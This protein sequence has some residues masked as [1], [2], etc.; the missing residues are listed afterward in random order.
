MKKKVN[1]ELKNEKNSKIKQFLLDMIAPVVLLGITIALFVYGNS[2]KPVT[3]TI[4][5][6]D[7]YSYEGSEDPITLE[8]GDY[9]LYVDPLTTYITVENKK[10][11][12]TWTSNPEEILTAD[13]TDEIANKLK[14]TLILEYSNS[15]GATIDPYYNYKYSI[16]KSIYDIQKNGDVITVNYSIGD[17]AKT[18]ICPPVCLATEF[19]DYLKKI[20]ASESGGTKIMRDVKGNYKKWDKDKVG[21]YDVDQFEIIKERYPKVLEEPI[22]VLRDGLGKTTMEKTERAFVGIGYSEEDY[23][24]DKELDNQ[25]ASSNKPIFNV[26]IQYKL[27]GNKLTVTV[28]FDKIECPADYPAIGLS[29]LPYFDAAGKD[30][31]GFMVVPEGG[32]SVINFNNGKT[33]MEAYASKIYGRDLCLTKDSLVHDPISTFGVIGSSRGDHS[34]IC[35]P[36]GCSSYATIYADIYRQK[37]P[38]NNIY[39]KYDLFQREMYDMGSQVSTAIYKYIDELPQ[40]EKITQ[41]YVFLDKGNYVDMAEA[42][43]EHLLKEYGSYMSKNSDSSTPVNVEIIGAADKTEQILGIPVN[44]PL[45][46][47]NFDEASEIANDLKNSVGMKNVNLKLV[48]WCNGGVKQTVLSSASPVSKLG[49]KSG[50]KSFIETAKGLGYNVSLN[51]IVMYAIDSDLF[52]GFFSFTDAAKTI[53]QERME[54]FKYSAVTFALREGTEPYYLL[55]TDLI[56]KY[57]DNL[58]ET[59]DNYGVGVS[60]DDFGKDLAADYYDDKFYSREKV[61]SLQSDLFKKLRDGGKYVV[62]NSGNEYAIPYVDMITNMDLKGSDYSILDENIPFLEFAIHG[63][64]NYTGESLNI[65]GDMSE[66]LLYSA[67]Y[68]AGLSFTY[69]KESPFTLQDTLYTHY[70]GCDYDAWKSYMVDIYSRYEKEL[71]HIFNQKMTNHEYISEG[72]SCT[73]Y[74]D[75]TKVYVNF[76]FVPYNGG[77]VSIPARDYIVKR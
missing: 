11:G 49:G 65:S 70:Y 69:M 48:G 44:R 66:E 54:I 47:T 61:K 33:A 8:S 75:G 21:K 55:H 35:I 38:C 12:K 62:I 51:G 59:A 40:D 32:G 71:G 37:S 56:F 27:E 29:I 26:T 18:Y 16:E 41:T 15:V 13:L 4:P 46:L 17:V 53:P 42:Y 14:S 43:R 23:K 1:Q 39:L 20:E 28:P 2:K 52:D 9:K 45:E 25:E 57:A 5:M 36:D 60:F 10:S 22:Y 76:N 6:P 72:V 19:E 68:G 50:L 7:M 77:G 34:Y 73:T 24:K 30:T 31:T 67:A 58:V 63:Y 64:V 74:E 3:N